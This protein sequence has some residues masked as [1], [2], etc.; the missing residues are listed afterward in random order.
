MILSVGAGFGN[1]HMAEVLIEPRAA[2]VFWLGIG[3][4]HCL[5]VWGAQVLEA[6][7]RQGKGSSCVVLGGEGLISPSNPS[8]P[9]LSRDPSA[10]VS[11]PT[12]APFTTPPPQH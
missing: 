3:G 11:G 5:G 12:L 6:K 8:W 7:N 1:A 4:G 2:P 10:N 9:W